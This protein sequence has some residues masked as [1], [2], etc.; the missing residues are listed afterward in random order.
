[1]HSPDFTWMDW[2]ETQAVVAALG[3][4]NMRFVGGAVRDS[5]LHVPV[6]DIDIATTLRPD[7]VIARAQV[8]GIKAVPTGIDHGTVTLV[9]QH[10][11]FEVTTLRRDVST[12]GRRAVVVFTDDWKADAARRDF[13]I[14]AL[15]LNN[16]RQLFDYFGGIDDIAARHVRFIGSASQRIR[17]DALR[18]LRFF[19]FSAR[20]AQLPL[21]ENGLKACVLRAR[22]M[23]ALSRERIR[24]ELL[25]LLA[26]AN[27][28]PV[29]E[30][31]LNHKMF[32]AFL[33][34]VT[35]LAAL[36]RLV[37]LEQD[38]DC[39]D[40]WRRLA[41]LLPA[42]AASVSD[43]AARLKVSKVER[44]RLVSAT[45]PAALLEASAMRAAIYWHGNIGAVDK[46]LMGADPVADIRPL[47]DI[48]K[49]WRAP[50]LPISGKHLIAAGLAA[51]PAVSRALA[52]FEKLWVAEDFTEAPAS[53]SKLVTIAVARSPSNL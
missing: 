22:D 47:L 11:P 23:M 3:S 32:E 38:H 2:P 13:T 36:E 9:T 43:I 29:L 7:E 20:F 31:M 26:A 28:L 27:P 24:D 15:Y 10:R 42:D 19:R 14:N 46:L 8:A 53:L 49:H 41:A 16:D 37:P 48:G 40:S 35:S 51:G 5:L 12:D 4:K 33:P 18:I 52:A 1:M 39:A 50:K 34:E 21:D 17:E 30:I 45:E 6:K 25:K 44:N